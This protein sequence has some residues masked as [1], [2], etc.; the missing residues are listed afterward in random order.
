MQ[1]LSFGLKVPCML[2]TPMISGDILKIFLQCYLSFLNTREKEKTYCSLQF[3]SFP[4]W[5]DW[6]GN[7]VVF[8]FVS[9]AAARKTH[10]L[11]IKMSAVCFWVYLVVSSESAPFKILITVL[12]V[13]SLHKSF[14]CIYFSC[15]T[16]EMRGWWICTSIYHCSVYQDVLV[17]FS[18]FG[19][20]LVCFRGGGVVFCSVWGFFISLQS[21]AFLFSPWAGLPSSII[22]HLENEPIMSIPQ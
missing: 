17:L 19:I 6:V 2:L 22:L 1:S 14:F 15:F 16:H 11:S 20:L 13:Y 3:H 5:G 4:S 18:V 8:L 21:S 12:Y 7:A 10:S 9:H